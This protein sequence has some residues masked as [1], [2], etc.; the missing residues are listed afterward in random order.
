MGRS[1]G[2]LR[3]ELPTALRQGGVGIL[4]VLHACFGRAAVGKCRLLGCV[5]VW[6]AEGFNTTDL[7]NAKAPLDELACLRMSLLS[8]SVTFDGTLP[9]SGRQPFHRFYPQQIVGQNV[10]FVPRYGQK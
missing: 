5:Y 6:I 10:P 4:P 2:R 7:K 1:I 9:E 8:S 3:Q